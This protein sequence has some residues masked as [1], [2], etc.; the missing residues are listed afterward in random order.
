MYCFSAYALLLLHVGIA[1]ML[2]VFSL[3]Y[4][5]ACGAGWWRLLAWLFGDDGIFVPG[6]T[7]PYAP[8]HPPSSP[9]LSKAGFLLLTQ[10]QKMIFSGRTTMQY[11]ALLSFQDAGYC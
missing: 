2:R 9:F 3:A 4:A 11:L 10:A 5:A 7:P 8:P 6:M 1:D